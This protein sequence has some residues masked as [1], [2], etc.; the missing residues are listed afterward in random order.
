MNLATDMYPEGSAFNMFWRL[1]NSPELG[2]ILS[3]EENSQ[4]SSYLWKYY[5]WVEQNIE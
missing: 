2:N 4:T 3:S 5:A 1:K